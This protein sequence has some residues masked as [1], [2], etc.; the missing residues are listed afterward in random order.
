MKKRR[1]FRIKLKV[2]N[3]DVEFKEGMEPGVLGF[4][5]HVFDLEEKEY[6]FPIFIKTLL[7]LKTSLLNDLVYTE[8]EEIEES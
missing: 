2:R 6:E 7:D 8:V 3:C 5:E 4:N 1:I